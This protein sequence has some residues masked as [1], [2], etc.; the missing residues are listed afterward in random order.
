M[1]LQVYGVDGRPK[2]G[3]QPKPETPPMCLEERHCWHE[4]AEVHTVGGHTDW[5]CCHCGR[6]RCLNAGLLFEHGPFAETKARPRGMSLGRVSLP[7]LPCCG[8]E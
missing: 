1:S 4:S 7:F 8:W 5:V 6:S 3:A 2:P